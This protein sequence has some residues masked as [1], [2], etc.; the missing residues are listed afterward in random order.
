VGWVS[1]GAS[2]G[3]G[4]A[5]EARRSESSMAITGPDNRAMLDAGMVQHSA[6][7]QKPVHAKPTV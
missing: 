2:C 6:W 4:Q 7:K 5:G 3:R 1:G